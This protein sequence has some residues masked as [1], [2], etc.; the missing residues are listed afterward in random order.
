MKTHRSRAQA[1]GPATR[2]RGPSCLHAVLHPHGHAPAVVSGPFVPVVEEEVGSVFEMG[3]GILDQWRQGALAIRALAHVGAA[4][5]SRPNVPGSQR[6]MALS[7]SLVGDLL[8]A[9]GAGTARRRRSMELLVNTVD[10]AVWALLAPGHP[11]FARVGVIAT[12]VPTALETGFRLGAGTEAVPVMQPPVPWTA[13]W[14]PPLP[15]LLSL[16]GTGWSS[17]TAKGIPRPVPS[18]F[19]RLAWEVGR[20]VGP[21]LAAMALARR[22]HGQRLGIGT[23]GWVGFAFAGG[24]ALARSRDD[25]QRSTTV[26]WDERTKAT[27]DEAR[28]GSRV[29]AALVHNVATVDPKAMLR[30]LAGAGSERAGRTLDEMRAIPVDTLRRFESHGTLL[31]QAAEKRPI[32]PGREGTRWVQNVQVRQLR[33]A[34]ERIDDS[35]GDEESADDGLRVVHAR[36]AELVVEYRGERITLTRAVPELILRL[37][38]TLPALVL[39]ATW[40]AITV[41][42]SLGSA[43]VWAVVPALGLQGLAIRRLLDQEALAR[44]CD[45]T[46]A[47]LVAGSTVICDAAIGRFQRNVVDPGGAALCPG[48]G[49]TQTLVLLLACNWR[50]LR[51]DRLVLSG[52]AAAGWLFA[53]RKPTPRAARVY[54]VELA[55][56]LMPAFATASVGADTRR[57]AEALD[58]HL[59][60]RLAERVDAAARTAATE[61]LQT[62]IDQIQTVIDELPRHPG[63]LDPTEQEEIRS[64]YQDE[65]D[66]LAGSDPLAVINW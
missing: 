44:R 5:Q 20:D 6:A 48:T 55:F 28:V 60:R 63:G 64:R 9:S 13:A 29:H 54:V 50:D 42:P 8:V 35:R 21:P 43:P 12:V 1:R 66:R 61:E 3:G 26:T 40:T 52:L 31:R 47:W 39:G 62:F 51:R 37:E 14:D 53:I 19:A 65:I 10:G 7:A 41:L 24:Y 23:L 2:W 32:S 57:E 18:R 27:I 33:R 46:T 36:G 25:A 22:S 49:A 58:E 17:L 59:D 38:P 4:A 45:R 11:I 30:H 34:I 56:L 16:R 15:R